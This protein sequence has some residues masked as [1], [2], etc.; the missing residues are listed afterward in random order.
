MVSIV[1]QG[2]NFIILFYDKNSRFCT[3]IAQISTA[4]LTLLLAKHITSCDNVFLKGYFLFATYGVCRPSNMIILTTVSSSFKRYKRVYW[5]DKPKQV[6]RSTILSSTIILIL[7]DNWRMGRFWAL[8]PYM[9]LVE[10]RINRTETW[11]HF[12]SINSYFDFWL[13]LG[14]QSNLS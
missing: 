14:I 6:W 1:E 3:W 11:Q 9:S 8:F 12:S 7:F 2:F 13:F 10:V 5:L 4:L